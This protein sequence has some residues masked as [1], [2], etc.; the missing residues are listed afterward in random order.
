MKPRLRRA[1]GAPGRGFSR[2]VQNA[3]G[4]ERETLLR[5]RVRTADCYTPAV[6]LQRCRAPCSGRHLRLRVSLALASDGRGLSGDRRRGRRARGV[7]RVADRA[8]APGRSA[9]GRS[10][11]AQRAAVRVDWSEVAVPA[12]P[13]AGACAPG[14]RGAPAGPGACPARGARCGR[15]RIRRRW[16]RRSRAKRLHSPRRSWTAPPTGSAGRGDAP[17]RGRRRVGLG[18]QRP[19]QGAGAA[20]GLA[21]GGAPGRDPLVLLTRGAVA[22]GPGEDLPGLAQSPVWGLVRSA[23]AEHPERFSLL[24]IDDDPPPGAACQRPERGRAT[25]RPAPGYG[26]MLLG[27]RAQEPRPTASATAG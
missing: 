21:R 1:P 26:R 22:I 10:R 16:A 23:Q 9:E 25:A 4:R 7:G 17:E 13:R 27:L 19:A 11:E 18:T 8:R 6:L 24:D 20:A 12:Q 5:V 15:S 2:R 14:R 3:G